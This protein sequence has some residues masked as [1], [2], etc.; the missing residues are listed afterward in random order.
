[1][2]LFLFENFFSDS[3]E[4]ALK[5]EEKRKAEEAEKEKLKSLKQK[6]KERDEAER[7]RKEERLKEM[8]RVKTA[9]EIEKEQVDAQLA[10]HGLHIKKS[11]VCDFN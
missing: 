6:M 5:K 4:E 8:N 7:R 1:M 11:G 2:F 3:E 10:I 9:A